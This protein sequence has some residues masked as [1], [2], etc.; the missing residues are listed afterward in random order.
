MSL[1][2][3]FSIPYF[4]NNKKSKLLK[5]L[6]LFLNLIKSILIV[7]NFIEIVNF[8]APMMLGHH[9]PMP[10]LFDRYHLQINLEKSAENLH[11]FQSW[12]V[13]ISNL[14]LNSL[15]HLED[16]VSVQMEM[17]PCAWNHQTNGFVQSSV[18]EWFTEGTKPKVSCKVKAGHASWRYVIVCTFCKITIT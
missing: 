14:K 15:F 9:L 8:I 2:R 6:K 11:F 18:F 16:F 1:C 5:I 17:C 10:H 13:I 4:T 12:S 7:Q 3:F